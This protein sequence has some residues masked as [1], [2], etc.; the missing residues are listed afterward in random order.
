MD[1]QMRLHSWR[2]GSVIGRDARMRV[3]IRFK[4]PIFLLGFKM[5]VKDSE[6][7]RELRQGWIRKKEAEVSSLW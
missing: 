3:L 1:D 4:S 2:E 7:E 5:S 6:M